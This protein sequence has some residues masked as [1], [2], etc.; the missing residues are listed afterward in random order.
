MVGWHGVGMGQPQLL[1]MIR[2]G[3][4]EILGGYVADITIERLAEI[5]RAPE[6]GE[7]AGPL[8]AVALGLESLRS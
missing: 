2:A 8:G 7:S 3:T 6:L 1:P 4:V 5:I